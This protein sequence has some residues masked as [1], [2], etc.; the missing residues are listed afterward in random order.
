MATTRSAIPRAGSARGTGA[1]AALA[2]VTADGVSRVLFVALAA[3][4]IAGYSITLPFAF[5]QRLSL[6]NV[7]FL[8]GRLLSFAVA[9]GVGM[10]LLLTVQV[11]AVRRA[12]AARRAGGEG[13]VG[14]VALVVSVLPTF[15]CCTPVIPTVLAT[16][17][18][19]ALS[20]YSTTRSLQRFFEV[21]QTAFFVGSLVLLALTSWWSLRRTGRAACLRDSGCE[22]RP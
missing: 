10:A 8:T 9:L 2:A 3:V 22:A 14:G 15:L 6:H 1:A 12:A 13:A 16:F 7:D 19:S 17:G 20:V 11:Y 21:H 5:T 4:I 18:L